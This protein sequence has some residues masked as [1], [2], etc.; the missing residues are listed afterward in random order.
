MAILQIG[1]GTASNSGDGDSIRD[2]FN[3]TNQNFAFLD[4]ARQNLTTG[5]LTA[6]GNITIN[7]IDPS[8]WTGSIF[9]NGF[10]VA[11]VGAL[12]G[13]GTVTGATYFTNADNA[14]DITTGAV[15]ITGGLSVQKNSYLN[16]V[17]AQQLTVQNTV[18]AAV[19]TAPTGTFTG[20]VSTGALT[21]TGGIATSGDATIG[22]GGVAGT[23]TLNV[24]NINAA[25]VTGTLQTASQTNITQL[26]TLVNLTITG[27]VI[28]ANVTTGNINSTGNITTVSN[29]V[30]GGLY[31]TG[32]AKVTG[33]LAAQNITAGIG[34]YAN[35]TVTDIPS[36]QHVTNKAYVNSVVAA[37]AVG[38]GG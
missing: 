3:K 28:S 31:S 5:N 34:S 20:A 27:N 37:F 26:G 19:L 8:Y 17:F 9:L 30:T 38:L 10:Q 29:V 23:N 33:N 22:T 6:Q 1:I 32:I 18:S 7:A 11:T 15:Q 36:N 12:F 16:N 24:N 13:G 21:V 4:T 14:T 2:A 35:I 25:T